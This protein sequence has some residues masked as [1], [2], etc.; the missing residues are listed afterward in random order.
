MRRISNDDSLYFLTLT[1]V[2]WV[3]VFSR[4]EY[5]QWLADQIMYC[6]KHKGFE[7]YAYVIMTN[8]L[9]FVARMNEG[10]SMSDFLRDFKSYTAK[11]LIDSI[12]N[13]PIE[14]RKAWMLSH[15]STHGQTNALNKEF[16][17]WQNGSHPTSLYSNE[18]IQQKI[19][20]IHDNPVRAGF[21]A[22]VHEYLYSSACPHSPIKVLE[23]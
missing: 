20:Y 11:K 17:F 10:L 14:S 15:F 12:A 22:D 7:L 3:D 19:D 16:Q 23:S 9:H 6:Q 21:V 4:H 13:N 2:D 18:V 5:K 8:H 1:V